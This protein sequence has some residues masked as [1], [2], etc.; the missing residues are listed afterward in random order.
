MAYEDC[1][2]VGLRQVTCAT[3]WFV[4]ESACGD[5]RCQ[6]PTFNAESCGAGEVCALLQGGAQIAQC[7]T[8]A[9]G[10]GPITCDCLGEVCPGCTQTGVLDFTCNTCPS[11]QCP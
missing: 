6:N 11:G 1:D 3:D 5:H 8:H 9:C 10:T 7:M 4:V 2:G